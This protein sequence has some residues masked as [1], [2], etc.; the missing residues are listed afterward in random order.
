MESING[1][2]AAERYAGGIAGSPVS[3]PKTPSLSSA[4]E[5]AGYLTKML[6]EAHARLSRLA[7]ALGGPEP[8]QG[9][10]ASDRP[11]ASGGVYAL[12]D[13]INRCQGIGQHIHNEIGRIERLI[14]IG[15]P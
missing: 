12:T 14:G 4:S 7:T 5:G 15:G 9:E 2:Y 8:T 11:Q 10:A 1:N 3:T 13:T 6:A